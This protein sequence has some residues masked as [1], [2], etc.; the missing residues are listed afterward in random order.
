MKYTNYVKHKILV[1]AVA[2]G[3]A[4]VA[5]TWAIGLVAEARPG[6][7]RP[8]AEQIDFARQTSDLMTS[9]V[10]AALLQEVNETTPA[11]VAHGSLSIGLIFNNLNRD[12]RLVGTLQPLDPDGHPADEFEHRALASAMAGDPLAEVERVAGR[13]YYR[14]S[15]PLTNSHTQCGMCHPSFSGLPATDSVGALML[16]VPIGGG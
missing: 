14:R 13:W 1:T 3:V 16:R 12:M 7:R 2:A 10:V 4:V 11:N 5:G 8:T 9:T 15:V 6:P